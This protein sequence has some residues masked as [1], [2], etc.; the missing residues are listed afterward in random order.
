MPK[1]RILFLIWRARG[2]L[3]VGL[4]VWLA[5]DLALAVMA[6]C[7]GS[8]RTEDLL[9][10]LIIFWLLPGVPLLWIL[11]RLPRPGPAAPTLRRAFGRFDE[12]V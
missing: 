5:I 4:L 2:F 3:V 10:E 9:A 1:T 7:N 11:L 6:I 12:T 8:E